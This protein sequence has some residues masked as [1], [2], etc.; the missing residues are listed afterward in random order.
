MLGSRPRPAWLTRATLSAGVLWAG[1]VLACGLA[2]Y[3]WIRWGSANLYR[4]ES[5]DMAMH[6]DFDTF[7][8]SVAAMLHGQ[9]MY[10]TGASV[11]NL[12][13]PATV[14]LLAPFGLFHVL[15][16]YRLFALGTLVLLLA[17]Y[18]LVARE[19]RLSGVPLALAFCA[20]FASSPLLSTIALG[21]VYGVLLTGLV[22]AWFA[23]RYGRPVLAGVLLGVVVAIKP[24]L[25]P[26]LLLPLALRDRRMLLAGV[27]GAAG[28][29][30][31][32]FVAAGPE[33]T[34]HWL[35]LM[36][37]TTI[38]SGGDNASLPALALRLHLPAWVGFG[39]GAVVVAVTLWRV[40]RAG[41]AA[42]SASTSSTTSSTTSPN[43]SPSTSSSMSPITLWAMT[44][45]TLLLSPVA[46][47]NYLV[48]CFP[49]A[50]VLLGRRRF[51]LAALLLSLPVIGVEWAWLWTG[52]GLRARLGH[53]FY[54]AIL[55]C[56][57]VALFRGLPRPGRPVT[58]P[59]ERAP[60]EPAA[61]SVAAPA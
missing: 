45:A 41:G 23:A 56:Y 48:L 2:G 11:P 33:Q 55:F 36:T 22:G 28:A 42:G 53:S 25:T 24:T 37:Q 32:A 35:R 4:V 60:T 16:A 21:Q 27:G 29:T 18:A 30:L 59:A 40:W 50:L 15:P 46:W 1:A 47:H 9:N 43:T 61:E 38:S 19:L 12:D 58:E 20:M 3:L 17:C 31:V 52:D 54:C 8:R 51:A 49:G 14:V 34:W 39:L 26:L 5:N 13:P 10:V 44:A 6:V 7:H 57:W